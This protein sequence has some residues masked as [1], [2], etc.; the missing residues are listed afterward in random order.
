MAHRTHPFDHQ[1]RRRGEERDRPDLRPLRRRRPEDRRRQ[2]GAP[3]A[4]RGR[5]VLRGAQGA[6]VLQG[7]GRVHDLRPGDDP[8]ARRRER[9][10][11]E[12]RPDGRHRPEEGRQGHDPRRLRRQHRRQ[13][14]ARLRRRRNRR[15]RNRV[16]LPRHERLQRAEA[17]SRPRRD[18]VNLL[19]FDLDGLAA[20]CER[21]GEKR[22]RA[23]QLFRW[24]H[25]RGASRLRRD[26]RPRA[27]RCATSSPARAEVARAAGR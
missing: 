15:G 5:G 9:D 24:I 23:T 20:F 25:Q 16:L 7:P 17:R 8:G 4:R 21:L 13:R 3:V 26:D 27:S 22:F 11:E 18:L 1:A 6:P 10:R 2:H 12:P 19:D 14:G